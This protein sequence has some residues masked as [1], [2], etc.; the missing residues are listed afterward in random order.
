ML[1]SGQRGWNEVGQLDPGVSSLEHS[2]SAAQAMQDFAEKPFAGIHP[3]TFGE[4][5]RTNFSSQL[6]D[7]ARLFDTGVIFPKP[8]H[9]VGVIRE[10]LF[11]RKR[12]AFP[13]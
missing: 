7:L 2:W 1:R 10:A 8:G 3:A 13:V 6:R 9:G 4:V 12:H 11:K 5:L